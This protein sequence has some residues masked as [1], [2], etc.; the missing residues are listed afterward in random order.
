MRR[1]PSS[2]MTTGSLERLMGSD[3]V[4]G[5]KR[6]ARFL[7]VVTVKL[8][9]LLGMTRPQRG[10]FSRICSLQTER[11]LGFLE[12]DLLI[13]GGGP[14]CHAFGNRVE[15]CFGLF[16]SG[17]SLPT[18]VL[19][20][21]MQNFNTLPWFTACVRKHSQKGKKAAAAK[22]ILKTQHFWGKISYVTYKLVTNTST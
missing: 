4:L 13:S 2:S 22:N 17:S 3:D 16:I 18:Q 12:N 1:I 11:W 6:P 20:F 9:S 19:P 8:L 5:Q 14:S 10:A 7:R 21:S 15:H